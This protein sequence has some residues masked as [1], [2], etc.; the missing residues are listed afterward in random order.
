MTHLIPHLINSQRGFILRMGTIAVSSRV[1]ISRLD[2]P[3]V[4]DALG[5]VVPAAPGQQAD[6]RHGQGYA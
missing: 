1:I 5:L 6:G 2:P 4:L 3:P